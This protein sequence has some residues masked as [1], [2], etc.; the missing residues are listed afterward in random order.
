MRKPKVS[1]TRIPFITPPWI[2]LQGTSSPTPD[3]KVRDDGPSAITHRGGLQVLARA[4]RLVRR[5]IDR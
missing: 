3:G 1:I 4:S 5:G 2:G